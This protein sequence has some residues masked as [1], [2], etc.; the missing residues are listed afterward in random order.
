MG[1]RGNRSRKNKPRVADEELASSQP[2]PKES[3]I[4]PEALS[5]HGSEV[6]VQPV[7]ENV[8]KDETT[9]KIPEPSKTKFA[10]PSRNAADMKKEPSPAELKSTS[11]VT[12]EPNSPKGG[13]SQKNPQQQN[14]KQ[15]PELKSASTADE[16]PKKDGSPSRSS[17][18]KKEQSWTPVVVSEE[19]LAKSNAALESRR[20][21]SFLT[22]LN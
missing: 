16:K 15:D 2:T 14:V 4:L 6:V 7:V 3:S 22:L 19:K 1:K 21:F 13:R 20:T 10:P 8:T 18:R 12:K 9:P 17:V 11:A 5:N